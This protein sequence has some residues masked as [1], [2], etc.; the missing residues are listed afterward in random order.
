MKI[1]MKPYNELWMIDK[2]ESKVTSINFKFIEKKDSKDLLICFTG[3]G[4][5]ILYDFYNTFT[6]KNLCEKM[7]VLFFSDEVK[8]FYLGGVSG[9]SIS[10]EDTIKKINQLVLIKKYKT[11]YIVGTSMGGYGSLL[12]GYSLNTENLESINILVFNPYT[13]LTEKDFKARCEFIDKE[14]LFYCAQRGIKKKIAKILL[15]GWDK[16]NYELE[17]FIKTDPKIKITVIYGNVDAEI[18][19]ITKIKKFNNLILKKFEC[20]QHNIALF[21]KENRQLRILLE[22]YFN[23]TLKKYKFE[24]ID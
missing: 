2:N 20:S 10:L 22:D 19:R 1:K 11:I 24:I 6:S 16:K 7:D 9:Y 3:Q 15:T 5:G 4:R 12:H 18:K 8:G 23:R 21:L 13:F 17:N 14:H